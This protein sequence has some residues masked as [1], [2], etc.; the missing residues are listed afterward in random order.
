MGAGNTI[1]SPYLLSGSEYPTKEEGANFHSIRKSKRV[2][3]RAHD[4]RRHNCVFHNNTNHKKLIRQQQEWNLDL[5][6]AYQTVILLAPSP[7]RNL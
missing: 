4:H 6:N 2:L 5:Y 1:N 7:R 3:V